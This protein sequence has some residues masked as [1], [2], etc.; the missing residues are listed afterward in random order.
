MSLLTGLIS[1]WKLDGNSNDAVGS[2]NGSDTTIS[3]SSANGKIIQGAGFNGTTSTVIVPHNAIYNTISSAISISLWTKSSTAQAN[4]Y[5]LSKPTSGG[6]NGWD[7]NTNTGVNSI[8]SFLV[9]LTPNSISGSA[10]VYDGNFHH[11]CVTYGS[12]FMKLYVDGSLVT[13]L[14]ATGTIN[15]NANPLNIG[16]FSSASGAFYTGAI[17]E[18][19]IWNVDI[20]STGVTQLYNGG[21]GLAYPFN[22]NAFIQ[23]FSA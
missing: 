18:I 4:K 1:Y 6:A 9:G 2:N 7:I 11:I 16:Y 3:Y 12:G 14:A 20:T 13:N 8:R 5:L 19:G 22:N 21:N 10:N 23:F 15:T 17:D